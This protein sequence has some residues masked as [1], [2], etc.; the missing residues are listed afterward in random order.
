MLK[1]PLH[2]HFGFLQIVWMRQLIPGVDGGGRELVEFISHLIR[3]AI[4]EPDFTGFYIPFPSADIGTFDDICQRRSLVGEAAC[5]LFAGGNV[6]ADGD[7]FFDLS[8]RTHKGRNKGVHPVEMSVFGAV[9]H[10]VMPGRYHPI[11][12]AQRHH[13][14]DVHVHIGV[15]VFPPT[16]DFNT[17]AQVRRTVMVFRPAYTQ[18]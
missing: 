8:V 17:P 3:P 14:T 15:T 16:C 7:V 13:A 1:M 4:I 5:G 18:T 10:L 12:F 2:A 6:G 11:A 9:T